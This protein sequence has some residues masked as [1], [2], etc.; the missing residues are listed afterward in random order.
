MIATTHSLRRALCGIGIAAALTGRPN[1]LPADR[2]A[3]LLAPAWVCS[4]VRAET[5]FGFRARIDAVTGFAETVDWY[6][7]EGCL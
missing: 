2:L 5:D 4:G 6:R 7:A 3:D 1:V